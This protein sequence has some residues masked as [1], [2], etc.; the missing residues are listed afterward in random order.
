MR[1]FK[2]TRVSFDP[3]RRRRIGNVDRCRAKI[4]VCEAKQWSWPTPVQRRHQIAITGVVSIEIEFPCVLLRKK[5]S[6]APSKV[7]LYQ[8][9]LCTCEKLGF[10][11]AGCLALLVALR[12]DDRG[13]V[14]P[15]FLMLCLF[16]GLVCSV[17]SKIHSNPMT[18]DCMPRQTTDKALHAAPIRV[19][20]EG[21]V[22]GVWARVPLVV[23]L[24]C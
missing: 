6:V 21:A 3:W 12:K 1:T 19:Q 13:K 18:S 2:I 9:I 8:I 17:C 14:V 23:R 15:Q 24:C 11:V 10:Q 7:C 20:R 4:R 16:E 22:S 5:E